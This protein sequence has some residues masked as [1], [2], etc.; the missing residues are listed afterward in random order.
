MDLVL[1][2]HAIAAERGTVA[3]DAERPLTPEGAERMREAA[4]G[5]ARLVTPQVIVSSPWLR[6][7]QTAEILREAYGLGKVRI[8]ETLASDDY[9][10]VIEMAAETDASPV[11]L[12]GHEP[13]MGE[14]LAYL[15]TGDPAGMAVTFK[16]GGAALVRAA[17]EPRAGSC[18]LEWF[19]P[20]GALRRMAAG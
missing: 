11:A 15:L 1:V 17:G 19:I 2:R 6:A 20:P 10:A 4:R 14:L 8:S 12:V 9:Q 18:W 5:L 3:N 7:V 13:W 16:K